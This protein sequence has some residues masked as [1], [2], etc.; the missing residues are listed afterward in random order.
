MHFTAL[1]LLA[2]ACGG[3]VGA[4]ARYLVG[5]ATHQL[6]GHN[7]PYGTLAVN[8]IG[9]LV[10][11]YLLVLMPVQEAGSP[12]IRLL[13]TAGILG[14]FTTFSAFSVETLVLA[15]QG[16]IGRAGINLG[17]T[18]LGCLSAVWVGYW[19]ARILHGPALKGKIARCK[20]RQTQ[21]CSTHNY[22]DT[23]RTA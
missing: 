18:M 9:S 17:L 2:V 15:Q 7:F 16:Q 3:A 14:G 13:V 12:A 1:N 10:I 23:T 21:P 5:T 22:S 8:V 19:L 6:L 11:G 20:Q 4:G